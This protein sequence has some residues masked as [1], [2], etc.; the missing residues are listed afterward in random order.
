ML[1]LKKLQ[2]N[3]LKYTATQ[4]MLRSTALTISPIYDAVGIHES[5]ESDQSERQSDL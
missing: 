1:S 5:T 4:K 3:N 2:T